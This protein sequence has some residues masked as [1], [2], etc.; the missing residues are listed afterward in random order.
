MREQGDKLF[1]DAR[2]AQCIF[3]KERS[4]RN[5]KVGEALDKSLGGDDDVDFAL[6]AQAAMISLEDV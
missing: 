3:K 2:S 4:A 5:D 6:A 1:A